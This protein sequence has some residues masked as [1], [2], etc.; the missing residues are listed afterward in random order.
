LEESRAFPEIGLYRL[1]EELADYGANELLL[2]QIAGAT[3]GRFNPPVR[4]LFDAGGRSI[5]S[6][7]ELWPGLLGLAILLN[8]AEVF[9]RKWRGLVQVLRELGS[10][11]R[12]AA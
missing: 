1:E 4:S 10:G 3:G 5:R 9:L 8:L 11:A 2:R 7:M 6:V 12:A